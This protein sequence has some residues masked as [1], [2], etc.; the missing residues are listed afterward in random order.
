[1]MQMLTMFDVKKMTENSLD[2]GPGDRAE[3]FNRR[4]RYTEKILAQIYRGLPG[5]MG[6]LEQTAFD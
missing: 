3:F 6:S 4:P 2:S 1:M 5:L